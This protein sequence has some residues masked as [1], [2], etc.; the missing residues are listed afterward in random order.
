VYE[1]GVLAALD[2]FVVRGRRTCDFDLFVGTSA[3]SLPAALLANGVTPRDMCRAVLGERDQ[4]LALRREDIYEIRFRTLPRALSRLLGGIGPALRYLRRQRQPL[5]ILNLLALLQQRLP[6]GVFSNA[7]LEQYVARI[8]SGP[9]MTNDFRAL[10][11]ELFIVATEL[12]RGE[13]VVFGPGGVEEVPISRAIRAST[14]IPL[15]FEPVQ[16]GDSWFVDGAAERAGHLDIPLSRGADLV[17]VVNPTVPI[18]NDRTVVCLPTL[19]GSCA[20][21][22]DLGFAGVAEQ[23]FRIN[24]RVKLDLELALQRRAR[25]EADILLLEPAPMDA[26]LFLYGSMNFSERIQVLNYGY[27]SAAYFFMD[28]FE[29]LE[30]R[31]AKYDME[32]SLEGIQAD[33]FLDPAGRS[34]GRR[35]FALKYS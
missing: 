13:R 4:R 23:I 7:A 11:K 10:R 1:L 20:S 21:L 16:V 19:S 24:T 27:N 30:R 25:P 35:R 2:D 32:V 22:R 5:T 15:F 3:G 26:T 8:L 29:D 9:G 14:A 28:R 6:P 33:R 12:D 17:I 18:Y 31:L 34:K